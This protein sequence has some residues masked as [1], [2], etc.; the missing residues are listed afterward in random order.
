MNVY[1]DITLL[2]G[3]DI[4]HNYLLEKVYQQIHIGLADT[5]T[6]NNASTIG[7]AFPEYNASKY[8]LGSKLRLFSHDK[9]TLEN[10]NAQKRLNR[11]ADYVHVTG[12]R[13]VPGNITSY[14]R[15]KRQQSKSNIE[16]LARRKAKRSNIN[17]EEALNRLKPHKESFLKLPFIK[18]SSNSSGHNFRLFIAEED[19]TEQI[20]ERFSC[21]GLSAKSSLPDF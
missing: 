20:N 8:K 9:L 21:Y 18:V 13:D 4:G 7:I 14:K 5:K 2:P 1:I 3:A 16:R 15:Y 19:C 17:L 10:F 11:L 6:A 12:I